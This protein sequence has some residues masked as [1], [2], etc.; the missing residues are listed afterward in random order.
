MVN[1]WDIVSIFTVSTPSNVLIFILRSPRWMDHFH[2]GDMI[3]VG[4]P[5]LLPDILPV[6]CLFC[7]Y[8]NNIEWEVSSRSIRDIFDKQYWNIT[9]LQFSLWDGF[10]IKV[11]NK[12]T[13]YKRFNLI[14]QNFYSVIMSSWQCLE[15]YLFIISTFYNI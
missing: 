12:D 4:V 9:F 5:T 6:R 14:A 15:R 7:G 11:T 10:I 2:I 3:Y 8:R 13:D 1:N